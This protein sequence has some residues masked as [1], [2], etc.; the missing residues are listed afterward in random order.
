MGGI[1]T[2]ATYVSMTLSFTP[3]ILAIALP[4]VLTIALIMLSNNTCDIER[5]IIAG[6][7][8]LA[9]LLGRTASRR[10][11]GFMAI[12]TLL[13][14]AVLAMLFWLPALALAAMAALVGYSS[15]RTIMQGSYDLENRRLIMGNVTSWCMLINA[16]WA[17]G[18][19]VSGLFGTWL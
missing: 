4:S 12:F 10:L 14:M 15:L 7:K 18:L 2:V 5:D 9:V 17:V 13:W 3:L 1:I 8:T 6:R 19:L 16:C 11:A